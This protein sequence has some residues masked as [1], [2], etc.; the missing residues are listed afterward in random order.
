MSRTRQPPSRPLSSRSAI[1]LALFLAACRPAASSAAATPVWR[2]FASMPDPAGV[3]GAYAGTSGGALLVAGGAN[4]PERMPWDGGRKAWYAEA[5]VLEQPDGSW[6]KAGQLPRPLAYG[7]SVS[8]HDSVICAGGGDANRHYADVFQIRWRGGGLHTEFLP[9]LPCAL[10]FMSGALAGDVLCVAGGTEEPGEQ[11][12]S[13]RFFA[14]DLGAAR[15]AWRELEPIPGP[16]RMLTVAAAHQ[17]VFYLFGGVALAPDSAGKMRRVHL[18]EA[19]AYRPSRGWARLPDLPKPCVA[20]PSPAPVAGGRILLLA[21]DDGARAGFQPPEK[22]P[23]FGNTLL[24]F[25]L[26][27]GRWIAAGEVPAPRA[28]APCAEWRGSFVVPSGEVRP[29]VRS[30]EVWSF[31]KY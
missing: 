17:G 7:V 10:A 26:S 5:Y 11:R 12:A 6:R 19:L 20:A 25:D 21:G 13:R 15:P 30:P 24:A 23:G 9:A 28:T 18:R 8:F 4:F 29:G 3:A 16:A 31:P 14:L 27:Q 2:Q 1:G 22:H